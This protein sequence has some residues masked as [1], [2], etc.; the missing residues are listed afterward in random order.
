MQLQTRT[1]CQG[2]TLTLILEFA[3]A[4]RGNSR[5]LYFF[6]LL[7]MFKVTRLDEH[8]ETHRRQI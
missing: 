2:F 6:S 3:A 1:K 4:A 5:L 7:E 8:L